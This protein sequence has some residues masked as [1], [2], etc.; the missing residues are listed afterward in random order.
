MT[1]ILLDLV[2]VIITFF[3]LKLVFRSKISPYH[4]KFWSVVETI[5]LVSSFTG[6]SLGLYEVH[7]VRAQSAFLETEEKVM[8]E[9]E[10]VKVN[11]YE[12][13]ELMQPDNTVG[14][15]VKESVQWFHK[16]ATMLEDGYKDNKWRKFIDYTRGFVFNEKG[17]SHLTDAN[18]LAFDWPKNEHLNPADIVYKPEM[19][20]TIDKLLGLEADTTKLDKLKPVNKPEF[21]ARYIFVLFFTVALALKLL[22]TYAEYMK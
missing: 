5:W 10:D 7:K 19:R 18:V 22:K 13:V 9:F 1:E 11:L 21:F 12:E 15:N 2:A 14:E 4:A 17:V 3:I 6:V 20:R 8:A 16:V